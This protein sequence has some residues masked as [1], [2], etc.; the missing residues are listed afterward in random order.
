MNPMRPAML[1]ALDALKTA[2]NQS[3]GEM[4]L[5]GEEIRQCE[6]AIQSVQRVLEIDDGLKQYSC[7]CA[8]L[9]TH[10]P[11]GFCIKRDSEEDASAQRVRDKCIG[12]HG[13]DMDRLK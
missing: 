9:G 4:L 2:R 12:A 5:T 6:L 13:Y 8:T 11:C 7:W 3:Y 10:A 1:E